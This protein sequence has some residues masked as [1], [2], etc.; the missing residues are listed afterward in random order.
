[1]RNPFIK[2][3]LFAALLLLG[4]LGCEP[5]RLA[6]NGADLRSRFIAGLGLDTEHPVFSQYLRVSVVNPCP[7]KLLNPLPRS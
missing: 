2:L 5:F 1:M 7:H 4:L 3:C 6:G